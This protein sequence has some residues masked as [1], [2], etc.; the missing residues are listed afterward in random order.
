MIE[1]NFEADETNPSLNILWE[2][3][4]CLLNCCVTHF[5]IMEPVIKVKKKRG[6]AKKLHFNLIIS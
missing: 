6:E 1:L 3:L 2:R 4:A 5:D